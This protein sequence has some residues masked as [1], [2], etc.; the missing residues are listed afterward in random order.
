VRSLHL[1][2]GSRKISSFGE[3]LVLGVPVLIC[4]WVIMFVSGREGAGRKRVATEDID[5]KS[6]QC[7]YIE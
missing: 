6:G 4:G 3:I 7:R 5:I 2:Q 1:V